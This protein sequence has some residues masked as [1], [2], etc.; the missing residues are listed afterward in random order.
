MSRTTFGL[1]LRRAQPGWSSMLATFR[2]AC[3]EYD[4]RAGAYWVQ[5]MVCGGGWRQKAIVRHARNRLAKP[6]C[7][8]SVSEAYRDAARPT[9]IVR[10]VVSAT[11]G[12]DGTIDMCELGNIVIP[13]AG[14]TCPRKIPQ[15]SRPSPGNC[16]P[17]L[18]SSI[19]CFF[20]GK[21][22]QK[23]SEAPIF[24]FQLI[25]GSVHC[26]RGLLEGALPISQTNGAA[27]TDGI[28]YS[29]ATEYGVAKPQPVGFAS[30]TETNGGM[31]VGEGA[32]G[33]D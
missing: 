6:L 16:H 12:I 9:L 20:Q 13:N 5:S 28:D 11:N 26:G 10:P 14:P 15:H 27:P 30:T 23:S 24:K 29:K 19:L 18:R 31:A 21:G 25:I 33:V 8:M 4:V 1:G 2:W 3:T 22:R 7:G 32:L 17:D